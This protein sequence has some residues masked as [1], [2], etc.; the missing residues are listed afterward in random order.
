[1]SLLSPSLSNLTSADMVAADM[2]DD[3]MGEIEIHEDVG[4]SLDVG[5]EDIVNR[6]IGEKNELVGKMGGEGNI[7]EVTVDGTTSVNGHNRRTH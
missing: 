5:G 6:E 7:G 1:M 3:R 4:G 2:V